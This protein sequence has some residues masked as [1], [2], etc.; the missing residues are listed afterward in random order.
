MSGDEASTLAQLKACRVI[1]DGLIA[2]HR[3]A[4][5]TP[6]GTGSSPMSPDCT[7]MEMQDKVRYGSGSV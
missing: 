1:I 2:T 7:R 4:S 3:G 5:S 6:P